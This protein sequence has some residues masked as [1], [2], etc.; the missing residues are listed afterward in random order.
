[1]KREVAERIRTIFTA[2][3]NQEALRLLNGFFD[4][5]RKD[6]PDLVKWAEP[7]L[8]EGLVMMLMP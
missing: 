4:D 5:C 7:A 3:D 8:P 6:A 2:L 1:M